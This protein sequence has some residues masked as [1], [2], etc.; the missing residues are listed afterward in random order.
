MI[1]FWHIVLVV[2]F[3]GLISL[4]Y[5]G[6]WG[7]PRSIPTV[8]VGTK[9]SD[10]SG[11]EVGT[12]KMISLSDYQGKVVMV[13]FWASWCLECRYEHENLLAIQD[14]FGE[15]PDFVMLGINYQD[16]EKDAL[17]YLEHYGSNFRHV[18]DVKGA[19]SI[20]F[21]VYGVPETFVF[22]QQGIIRFKYVG[23]IMGP[24]Y[25]HVVENVLQP[26]LSKEVPSVS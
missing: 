4:F 18:R 16:K 8:L 19:I 10:F 11:L 17:E 3:F 23:P 7:D 24:T 20:D 13:N 9:A 14:R 26:L 2:C 1:R 6:L 22:D 25:T 5:K 21:G 12:G 15:N